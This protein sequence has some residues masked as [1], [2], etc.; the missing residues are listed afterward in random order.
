MYCIT[1]E[2]LSILLHTSKSTLSIQKVGQALS[3]RHM[4]LP[5]HADKYLFQDVRLYQVPL[6]LELNNF[7]S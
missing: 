2:I 6:C 4:Y 7:L 1:Q 5:P 3:Y